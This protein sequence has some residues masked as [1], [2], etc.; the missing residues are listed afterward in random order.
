M[1]YLRIAAFAAAGLAA[2]APAVADDSSTPAGYMRTGKSE[3]CVSIR[4]LDSTK[5]LNKHQILFRMK[6]GETWLNEPRGCPGLSKNSALSYEVHG[7][8]ICNTTIVTL[9][10]PAGALPSVRGSC[11]LSKFEKLE[12]KTA[13]AN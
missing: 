10:E 12:K 5:I 4:Q 8:T 2:A 9:L 7:G 1:T 13:A 3:S 6:N 11:G